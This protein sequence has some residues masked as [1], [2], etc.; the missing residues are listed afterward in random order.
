MTAWFHALN[1]Q[2]ELYL[3]DLKIENTAPCGS[4]I[5]DI[6]PTPSILI[7]GRCSLAPFSLALF[8]VLDMQVAGFIFWVG[9]YLPSK[10]A[11]VKIGG[12]FWIGRAQIGPAERAVDLGNS[13]SGVL[14]GLPGAENGAGG[15]LNNGHAARV[16]NVEGGS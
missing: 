15:I 5:T 2:R 1:F 14:V 11:G 12:T 10:K 16:H 8:A 9:K 4:A 13:D 7:G 3:A 6:R